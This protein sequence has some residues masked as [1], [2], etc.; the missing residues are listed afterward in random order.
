MGFDFKNPESIGSGWD[1]YSNN[2]IIISSIW[3]HD[4][5]FLHINQCVP[6]S[7]RSHWLRM[8]GF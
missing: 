1:S 5:I 6:S 8:K 2:L 4:S 7:A 3:E